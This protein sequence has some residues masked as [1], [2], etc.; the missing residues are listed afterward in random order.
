MAREKEG[1]EMF[2]RGVGKVSGEKKVLMVDLERGITGS[3]KGGER[4]AARIEIGEVELCKRG[5]TPSK[6]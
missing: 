6:R 4:N 2:G 1:V 3:A 5:E